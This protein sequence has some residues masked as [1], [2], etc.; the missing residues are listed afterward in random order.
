MSESWHM[1]RE[2]TGKRM[3]RALGKT[4][5]IVR[6]TNLL[7]LSKS[8]EKEGRE[9]G[10]EKEKKDVKERGDQGKGE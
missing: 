8:K 5:V 4:T 7:N 9:R 6:K 2:S 3:S 10:E 1:Q